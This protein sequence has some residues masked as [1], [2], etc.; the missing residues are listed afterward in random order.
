M[1]V[2]EAVPV[3]PACKAHKPGPACDQTRYRCTTC[4][5]HLN[6][7]SEVRG[8]WLL[9]SEGHSIFTSNRGHHFH[10]TIGGLHRRPNWDAVDVIH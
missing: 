8:H 2:L 9:H 1:A 10:Q 7:K 6:G 4:G 3:C 5:L